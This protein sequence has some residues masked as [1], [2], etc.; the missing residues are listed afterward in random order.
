MAERADASG[1]AGTRPSGA[2]L[3]FVRT[4]VI[5]TWRSTKRAPSRRQRTAR[6]TPVF[7]PARSMS[8]LRPSLAAAAGRPRLCM[9]LRRPPVGS[10]GTAAATALLRCRHGCGHCLRA[11][12]L[13][14][15]DAAASCGGRERRHSSHRGREWR[16]GR[17]CQDRPAA[18]PAPA[19]PGR[20][21][22]AG[23]MAAAAVLP[24]PGAGPRRP[25]WSCRLLP[26]AGP[27]RPPWSC[28]LLPVA[29]AAPAAPLPRRPTRTRSSRRRRR[30][31]R[32]RPTPGS[33]PVLL[34]ALCTTTPA[35]YPPLAGATPAA[36]W[37]P[38][39]GAATDGYTSTWHSPRDP[40]ATCPWPPLHPLPSLRDSA[41]Q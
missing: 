11:P 39:T 32:P 15:P 36:C 41:V 4:C 18:T 1:V 37:S 9:P 12:R 5:C 38:R 24:P 31:R 2:E 17:Q 35:S 40:T 28:R 20:A 27:R 7:L 16:G 23:A 14:A 29:T 25:P 30:R 34:W 10:G 21:S 22:T 33:C 19:V 3:R 13:H 6:S 26:G 8:E